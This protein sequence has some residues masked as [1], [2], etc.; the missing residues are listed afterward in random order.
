MVQFVL[1]ETRCANRAAPG[2]GADSEGALRQEIQ[3]PAIE[4]FEQSYYFE[5]VPSPKPQQG[6]RREDAV[7]GEIGVNT[8]GTSMD[9][10]KKAMIRGTSTVLSRKSTAPIAIAVRITRQFSVV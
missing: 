4:C 6:R 2:P 10:M 5:I 7:E 3:Q 9:A 1:T 8:H